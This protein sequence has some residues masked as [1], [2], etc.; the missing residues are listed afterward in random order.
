MGPISKRRKPQVEAPG[1]A[2]LRQ[3]LRDEIAAGN[4][5]VDRISKASGL[6]WM[7]VSA[8]EKGE[9]QARK[10]VVAEIA[11]ALG[12]SEPQFGARVRE[13]AEPYGRD[14]TPPAQRTFAS[15]AERISYALGVLDM[16]STSNRLVLETSNEV[17]RAISAASAALLAPISGP[18]P[19]APVKSDAEY[20]A[21]STAAQAA[22]AAGTAKTAGTTRRAKGR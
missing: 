14:L 18:A 20:I 12:G 19:A 1:V 2:A 10:R 3:R 7:T 5:T 13:R 16:A 4:T 8:F 9:T 6:S 11:A 15:E 22:A 21:E 17:S